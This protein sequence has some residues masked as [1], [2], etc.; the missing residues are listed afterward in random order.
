MAPGLGLGVW[1]LGVGVEGLGFAAKFIVKAWDS[2]FR[3]GGLGLK[4]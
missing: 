3:L 1:D 4:V 2:R